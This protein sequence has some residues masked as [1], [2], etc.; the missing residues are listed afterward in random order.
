MERITREKLFNDIVYLV[1]LRSTCPK[2]KVGAILIKDNRII[3]MGYNGVLPNMDH[4]KGIDEDGITHTVH[5]EANI[6]AFCAKEGIPTKGTT[7]M[8]T[9]S[10]CEKCAELIIQSGIKEVIFLEQYRID[11]AEMLKNNG[12]KVSFTLN[13]R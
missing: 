6:I 4:S 10:P 3:A 9:L 12:V 8:T 7:L 2:K 13:N 1:S 11:T 5:A